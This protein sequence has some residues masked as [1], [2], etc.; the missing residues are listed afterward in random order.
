MRGGEIAAH[1][2][3][4]HADRDTHD[5]QQS[6][7]DEVRRGREDRDEIAEA[8]LT[9]E[10][11]PGGIGVHRE[12]DESHGED[13]RDRDREDRPDR[14]AH[15]PREVVFERRDEYIGMPK[16]CTFEIIVRAH[17]M[18]PQTGRH[19][20]IGTR[21]MVRRRNVDGRGDGTVEETTVDDT[22]ETLPGIDEPR[23]EADRRIAHVDMDC[24]YAACERLRE[25]E[26]VGRAVVVG[27][28][29]EPDDDG[30]VVASASYEAREH[31]IT[32]AQPINQ[33]LEALPR[34]DVMPADYAGPVAH[35]RPVDHAYYREISAEVM[36]ILH[37]A[38]DAVRVASLDEAY[39]DITDRTTWA[40]TET[41][42]DRLRTEIAEAVGVTASVG[43][44]P[45]VGVAKIA[46]D[47]DKPDGL[48]VVPPDEVRAFLDDLPL[49]DLHGVGPVTAD[50]L[51]SLDCETIG[52]VAALEPALIADRF[53]D[54]GRDLLRRARGE[55]SSVVEPQGEPKSLS[56]ESS[57]GDARED[58]EAVCETVR[59]LAADVAARAERSG[60]QYRTVGIKVVRP[61][62]E[63][64]TRE[65]TFGGPFADVDL[66]EATALELLDEFA[67]D[68]VRKVGVRV[69]NLDFGG[70][71]RH[72]E[73]FESATTESKPSPSFTVERQ[74]TLTD[75][76]H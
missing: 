70:D 62:F 31:G 40:S 35:Y 36:D 37:G 13:V 4:D 39:L 8:R 56:R 23:D 18:R 69:S 53:G 1:T 3:G 10:G 27:M 51:H 5:G 47:H 54:R 25:P 60:A 57:L 45:T 38:A 59:T 75:F 26:L 52:D 9:L 11:L 34:A 29:Y 76:D 73:E 65:R 46:S 6:E 24:F 55:G 58:F 64:N 12:G 61:P 66:V 71:Q 21:W 16:R 30:G 17:R 32:S 19:S 41:F 72:L 49:E 20:A 14:S 42:G 44:A 50:A 15:D 2:V 74:G 7:D 22:V 68:P 33:A 43:I 28:G 67:E 63:I 48:C